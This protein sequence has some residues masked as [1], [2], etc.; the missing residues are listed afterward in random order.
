MYLTKL[1]LILNENVS[2]YRLLKVC[3]SLKKK[4]PV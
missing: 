2:K 4:F 3:L 1:P